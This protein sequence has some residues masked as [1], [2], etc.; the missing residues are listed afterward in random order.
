MMKLFD[1]Q[2]ELDIY[3]LPFFW[4]D[5]NFSLKWINKREIFEEILYI[6][7]ISTIKEQNK[8]GSLYYNNNTAKLFPLGKSNAHFHD[9][10]S[11]IE[12]NSFTQ[13]QLLSEDIN[14]NQKIAWNNISDK[15]KYFN[16]LKI[17]NNLVFLF[18]SE[19]AIDNK[20]LKIAALKND[21]VICNVFHSFE[22]SLEWKWIV[23]L[24]LGWKEIFI[25]LDNKKKKLEFQKLRKEKVINFRKNILK[26]WA[27]HLYFDEKIN[28]FWELNKFFKNR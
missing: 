24:K 11:K 1:E 17:K 18:T 13:N 3:F 19:L 6:I 12:N 10:F 27:K 25:N 26:S 9:Y 20:I 14:K 2:R 21:L 4:E 8:F 28:V 23:W 16:S 7:W 15:L 22:N 5:L